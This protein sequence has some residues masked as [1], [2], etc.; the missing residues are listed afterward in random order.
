VPTDDD[1]YQTSPVRWHDARTLI[2]QTHYPVGGKATEDRPS[3]QYRRT[4]RLSE[5]P[6]RQDTLYTSKRIQPTQ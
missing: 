4:I 3:Y 5:S 1:D 2:V 6:L